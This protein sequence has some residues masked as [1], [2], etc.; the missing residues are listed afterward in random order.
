ME[1][2]QK[3]LLPAQDGIILLARMIA[4]LAAGAPKTAAEGA[5]AAFRKSEESLRD[6]LFILQVWR[7]YDHDTADKLAR[8]KAGE[9]M[10]Q[11][12][13]KVLESREK[14][15]EREKRDRERDKERSS[16]RP[17]H[18]RG[19]G[20]YHGF[21]SSS[22]EGG[23]YNPGRGGFGGRGGG[24]RGGKRPAPDLKCFICG[25]TGHFFKNC[26]DKKT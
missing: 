14:R 5:L 7:R 18:P 11:D 8:V 16:S 26:P 21:A 24:A 3:A 25:K 20:S 9:F 4:A 22:Q 23:G 15:M 19:G 2:I 12:L 13:A 17:K 6:R 1:A 10:D